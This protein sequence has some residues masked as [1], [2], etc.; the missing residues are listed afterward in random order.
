[1]SGKLKYLTKNEFKHLADAG[2]VKQRNAVAHMTLV[3]D[4]SI[5]HSATD[6]QMR[7]GFSMERAD[8][9]IKIRAED[10]TYISKKV[11]VKEA[12]LLLKTKYMS[13]FERCQEM[14]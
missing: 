1:M 6:D 3:I 14:C 4:K 5:H 13:A 7:N 11:N 8:V 9:Y 10:V 2:N 12:N